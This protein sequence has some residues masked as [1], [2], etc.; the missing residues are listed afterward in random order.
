MS[1]VPKN[2]RSRVGPLCE[3]FFSDKEVPEREI[4]SEMFEISY[5]MRIGT[6]APPVYDG[7]DFWIPGQAG[8][9]RE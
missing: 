8:L 1:T 3:R 4:V 6:N 7:G 5:P 9:R 2:W